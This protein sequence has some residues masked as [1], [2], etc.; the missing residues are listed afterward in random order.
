MDITEE[1]KRAVSY[2]QTGQLDLAEE[3][4]VR[5]NQLQKLHPDPL[6]LLGVVAY[7]RGK[8]KPAV[9]MI[10]QA[11]RINPDNPVYYYSLG[12][13]YKENGQHG[14][15]ITCYLKAIDLRPDYAEA[16]FDLGTAYQNLNQPDKAISA[17]RGALIIKPEF[18]EALNNVGLLLKKEGRIDEAL[19]CFKQAVQA[20]PEFAVAYYN[21]GN[22]FKD[23]GQPDQAIFN[24]EKALIYNP[25]SAGTYNNLGYIYLAQENLTEAINCFKKAIE[26]D[27]AYAEAM[28]NMGNA[29]AK[30]GQSKDAIGF[31]DRALQIRPDLPN[32]FNGLGNACKELERFDEA[33]DYFQKALKLNPRFAEAYNNLGLVYDNLGKIEEARMCYEKMLEIKP[34]FG[35]EVRM[36]MQLPLIYESKES[37]TAARRKLQLNLA[38]LKKRGD[39]LKDPHCEVGTTNFGLAFH[40]RDEK[41]I[42]QEIASFYL[43]VCPDLAWEAPQCKKNQEKA[44]KIKIGMITRF[45]YDHTIGNLYQGLIQHLSRDKFHIVIFRFP[46]KS[47]QIAKAINAAADEVVVL[48]NALKKARERIGEFSLDILFYLELGM[49][50]LTY[51]LAFSR[52]APVQIKRGFQITMGIPAID[53]FISS[54]NAEPPDAQDHYF[55]KLIRLKRT[56]YYYYRPKIESSIP[57]RQ[58]FGLQTKDTLYLCPQSLFKLHPDF[59]TVIANI[60]SRDLHGKLILLEGKH[61]YWKTLYLRRLNRVVPDANNRIQ[62][63]PKLTRNDFVALFLVADAV[64]DT[65]YLSGGNTS[66]E[67]FAA[68]VPVVTWPSPLLPGRLTY[69][70]YRQMGV[71][72][73]VAR[74]LDDYVNIAWKLANDK[75]WRSQVSSK[76]K[77]NSVKLFEDIEAV[78]ELEEFFEV[79]VATSYQ[80]EVNGNVARWL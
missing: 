66:L 16:Y 73:C 57:A 10:Q 21:L 20:Y 4:Y 42:R 17:Y 45:L 60:L 58:R 39:K 22:L 14:N 19:Q 65:I 1:L 26:L 15:A 70:F 48:P 46:G 13:T 49:D 37:M 2:H 36:A 75:K 31:Y 74:D 62:F 56:G 30:N 69:G 43:A 23:C 72:D 29:L 11:I 5:L 24:Y 33:I 38:S 50:P 3:M 52:L 54:N 71:S 6:H 59:D 25:K 51:F 7:Q 32:A 18:A 61:P 41:R 27:P 79:A 9:E 67:C 63:L 76:I 28:H 78:R 77:A 12:N 35:L 64:L 68:G 44:G 80:D 34:S 47:D 55:E 53:Y 8:I 40:G